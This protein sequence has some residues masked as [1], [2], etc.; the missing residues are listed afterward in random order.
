MTEQKKK[1]KLL[2]LS[3]SSNQILLLQVT[4][5]GFRYCIQIIYLILMYVCPGGACN[6]VFVTIE[7][8]EMQLQSCGP[9]A[10]GRFLLEPC[11]L[12]LL[13]ALYT[14]LTPFMQTNVKPSGCLSRLQCSRMNDHRRS[15]H[16]SH[17][18]I[19]LHLSH[20]V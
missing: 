8:A 14:Q 3:Y 16:K 4:S 10:A 15:I 2:T 5:H 11:Y 12:A 17:Q 1:K 9:N 20:N 13:R 6:I 18:S 19:I 7:V